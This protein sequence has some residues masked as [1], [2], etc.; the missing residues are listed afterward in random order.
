MKITSNWLKEHLDTKLDENQIIEKLTDVGLEVESVEKQSGEFDDFI[1]AK[2]LK[3]EK[4]PDADKLKVC[5]VD[6][7]K[8]NPVKVVCGAPNAIEG[9]LTIYAPPGSV[10][11]KNQMKL[12]VSKI[13]GVSSYGMLCS[14]S[15]LNLSDESDGITEL[16]SNDFKDKIGDNYFPKKNLNVIDISIT[17]N[18]PDCLGVRGIARDLAAAG[19]GKFKN[20][21]EKKLKQ[22]GKQTVN[23]KIEND[24]ACTVFGSCLI[25]DVKNVESPDWLKEKIIS[26]GQKPISAIVDITNYVMLDL[27]RP[28]HAYDVD[29]IDKEIIVRNS[30]KD[31]TFKALDNKE[32]K[33]EEGMC[34]ISDATGV[35][36][37]GGIIGGTRSGTELNTKNIL[38][39]SAYFSPR[40]IRKSSKILNIDTDAKFR[41]ER[42]IDPLSIE[43]GLKKAVSLIQEIC[44]G[45]ASEFDIQKIENYKNKSLEFDPILF[46]KITGVK[47]EKNEIIKILDDLGFEIKEEKKIL[48]LK[49]PSWRPDI[50]QEVDVVEELIR[51]KGYD[52]INMIEPQKV[53][54]K[55]TLNKKQKLFHFLQRA[56]ASKGYLEAITWSFTDSKI[57]QLFIE[58]NKEIKI[59][60]P[61]SSDLDVLRSSIFSN[62]IIH[63]NKNLG[64]GFKDLSIFEIG[65]TFLGEKPGEQQTVV[66][67]L[68]SGKNSR[69]N[70]LEKERL[71]DVFDVK[72]DVIQCLT[73]AGYDKDKLYFDIETPSYYHPGKSGRVFLN[74][75]KEK[76]IAFFGDIHPNILKKLDIKTEA[77]VGFEIFLDNIKQ[78]KKSLKDQKTQYKFS[79]FQKSERD[80]AFILD[81]NFQVQELI[82]VISSVDK[83]LIKSVKV[84]DVYEGKNIEEDKKSVALNVTIQSS[85][86]T[87]NEEDLNKI[88]QTIISTVESKIDAKIR[89]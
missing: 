5:D 51:I 23:V 85:E 13:R 84:F 28:L 42:G 48:D 60:N 22:D 64:R 31:E 11:P 29:K 49:I 34:V 52:Q 69:Q 39:E 62:L 24:Q 65:P 80:F 78:P 27:N 72:S 75:G 82:D 26:I 14:E 16:S 12:V 10:I 61:I 87:L 20:L 58:K 41:F 35:L 37:L 44:G 4:H 67:G 74:K 55:E 18:R 66:G 89:S 71:V 46:E 21:E 8:E 76:I 30:K 59:V 57:N 40:S 81:K 73:E 36:G 17:P 45:I 2:I 3:A 56:V 77:L 19:S 9:L 25:T 33:L 38:I 47:I 7:G 70:W 86:K 83:D 50:S 54:E 68:K 15:E 32:Y 53:R 43:Q 88:N 1:V 63:L 6:V 79:D